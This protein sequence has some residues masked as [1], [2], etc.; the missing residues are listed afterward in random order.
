[1]FEELKRKE[2]I[3]NILD[4]LEVIENKINEIE[5]S[6]KEKKRDAERIKNTGISQ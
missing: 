2:T 6:L 4:R 3:K 5:K 1:M